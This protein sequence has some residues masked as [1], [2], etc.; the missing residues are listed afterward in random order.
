MSAIS[1]PVVPASASTVVQSLPASAGGTVVSSTAPNAIS[2]GANGAIANQITQQEHLDRHCTTH[3]LVTG[4]IEKLWHTEQAHASCVEKVLIKIGSLPL[5]AL[6]VPVAT[7]EA[8]VRGVFAVIAS[9]F[10]KKGDGQTAVDRFAGVKATVLTVFKSVYLAFTFSPKVFDESGKVW[11]KLGPPPKGV[12]TTSVVTNPNAVP[13]ADAHAGSG[14][15]TDPKA[16]D[17]HAST[18]AAHASA[19]GPG[20][21]ATTTPAPAAPTTAAA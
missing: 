16:G 9:I 18:P 21:A 17:A 11:K 2:V 14:P 8:A 5:L 3:R 12:E 19:D 6:G 7:V 4:H 15:T 1:A 10:A 13:V 20:A